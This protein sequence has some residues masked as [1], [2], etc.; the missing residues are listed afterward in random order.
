[1]GHTTFRRF[2]RRILFASCLVLRAHSLAGGTAITTDNQPAAVDD[3]VKWIIRDA[4]Y[5]APSI[6]HD[7]R[8]YSKAANWRGILVCEPAGTVVWRLTGMFT[9]I[10][11]LDSGDNIY[12]NSY[13]SVSSYTRDKTLRWTTIYTE[14]PGLPPD[15]GDAPPLTLTSDRVLAQD[16]EPDPRLHLLDL[17]G[18]KLT[19]FA[20]ANLSVADSRGNFYLVGLKSLNKNGELRWEIPGAGTPV[21]IVEDIIYAV[22]GAEIRTYRADATFVRTYSFSAP[23]GPNPVVAPEGTIYAPITDGLEAI[24]WN[25]QQKWKKPIKMVSAVLASADTMYVVS[26]EGDL[27]SVNASTGQINWTLDVSEIT[28]NE[29]TLGLSGTFAPA[30][31]NDGTIYINR[32]QMGPEPRGFLVAIEG[33]ATVLTA[34]W[35]TYRGNQQRTGQ[36]K[37]D[38]RGSLMLMGQIEGGNIQLTAAAFPLGKFILQSSENLVNWDSMQTV[39]GTEAVQVPTTADFTFYLI[40]E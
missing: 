24:L 14:D 16:R 29:E 12:F 40:R 19:N 26:Q 15:V 32:A 25:G 23:V 37:P 6:G 34:G 3:R 27:H 31:G 22:S 4:G 2:L 13:A 17:N 7:G 1:M 35:P 5:E 36:W 11:S 39:A 21:A 10:P 30:L 9:S 18:Q 20:G 38:V 33:S 28:D 8:I